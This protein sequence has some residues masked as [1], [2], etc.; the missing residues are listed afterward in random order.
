MNKKREIMRRIVLIIR[1][2]MK[3]KMKILMRMR[4]MRTKKMDL[5]KKI[6]DRR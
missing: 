3:M 5:E 6:Y 2:R 1:K 4:M